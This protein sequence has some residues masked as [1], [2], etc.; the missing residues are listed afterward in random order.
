MSCLNID[1]CCCWVLRHFLTSKV[2]SVAS[3][4]E[5]EKSD[6][7]CSEALISAWGSFTCRKSTTR[8]PRL[9]FPLL[10]EVI[11]VL[12]IFTLWKKNPSTPA[13]IEPANLG[14]RGESDNHWTTGV[15][16]NIEHILTTNEIFNSEHFE[17][18]EGLI[19]KRTDKRANR[20]P[21]PTTLDLHLKD[22]TTKHCNWKAGDRSNLR[23][24]EILSGCFFESR[25]RSRHFCRIGPRVKG[26][27]WEHSD[28]APVLSVCVSVYVYLKTL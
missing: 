24:V 8:D 22:L 2:I 28:P 26:S 21:W 15:D 19:Q 10:K 1:G 3:D 9:Y 5:R 7:F 13:G 27:V 18:R 11:P 20:R 14:S 12:R 16:I 17:N 4:I 6:K 25:R 23:F